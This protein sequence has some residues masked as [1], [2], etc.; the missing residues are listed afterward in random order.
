MIVSTIVVTY[1]HARYIGQA[2]DSVLTQELGSEQEVLVCD[3]CSSDRTPDIV[4]QYQRVQPDQITLLASQVNRFDWSLI[5]EAVDRARGEY[6]AF[7][8]GDDYW[9]SPQ[10]L[11]RQVAFL[12]AN[13][14]CSCCFHNV[15]VLDESRR[16]RPHLYNHC[17][18][19]FWTLPDV[20][21]NCFFQAGSTI[22]PAQIMR[23]WFQSPLV[24]CPIES[25]DWALNVFAAQQGSIGYVDEV[26]SVYRLHD[27]GIWSS[28]EQT[29]K[30]ERI[31]RFYR[32]VAPHVA[33]ES[34]ELIREMIL[35]RSYDLS[36]EY[37][38]VRNLNKAGTCLAEVIAA[39]PAWAPEYIPGF[40]QGGWEEL[41]R[42]LWL[43]RHPLAFRT[44]RALRHAS[45]VFSP[46]PPAPPQ[47]R[48]SANGVSRRLADHQ[49]CNVEYVNDYCEP[50]KGYRITAVAGGSLEVKGWAVD[51]ESRCSAKGVE[52]E[53]GGNLY[54]AD[55]GT[56]RP[57]VAAYFGIPEMRNSGFRAVVNLDQLAPGQHDFRIRILVGDNGDFLE[58]NPVGFEIV[59]LPCLT[60]GH[61][62][63]SA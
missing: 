28:L 7:L 40:D 43:Y 34:Q 26:M 10:K 19:T 25:G 11:T 49:D 4:R 39:R 41:E 48:R 35:K 18:R 33:V 8:E 23:R 14:D 2:L 3:D 58:S 56:S 50:L 61:P 53:L 62:V 6:I 21:R 12:A 55:Y 45:R 9:T 63:G 32:A 15:L 27:R 52:L 38:R 20:L 17:E 57:D 24:Q 16:Q 59:A 30:F 13:H 51:G 60:S 44:V 47:P 54:L 31:L 46:A 36:L 29:A 1:N 42:R 37:E 5:A 22:F